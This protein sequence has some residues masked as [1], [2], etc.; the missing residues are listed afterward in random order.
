MRE[1]DLLR[2]K[3]LQEENL[4]SLNFECCVFLSKNIVPDFEASALRAYAGEP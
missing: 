2:S 3:T 4:G 1:H